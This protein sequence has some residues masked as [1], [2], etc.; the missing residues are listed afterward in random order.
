MM[1]YESTDLF[2]GD[3]PDPGNGWVCEEKTPEPFAFANVMSC[4]RSVAA[5]KTD[6]SDEE[7]I[8]KRANLR[9]DAEK[10]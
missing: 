4:A 7:K 3:C 10:K 1:L 9:K 5:H 8:C 6:E 2:G